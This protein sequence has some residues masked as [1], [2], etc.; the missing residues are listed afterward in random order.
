MVWWPASIGSERG[1]RLRAFNDTERRLRGITVGY[2]SNIPNIPRAVTRYSPG[3]W[4][5]RSYMAAHYPGIRPNGP[6]LSH[7]ASRVRGGFR[8][9]AACRPP[10]NYPSVSNRCLIITTTP[11]QRA[12]RGIFLSRM[13]LE[14]SG[15]R[16]EDVRG[17]NK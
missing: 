14:K 10:I 9:F 8:V 11:S 2:S 4:S 7:G 3:S 16:Y 17:L 15:G 6:L 12:L 1:A 13:F 5:I